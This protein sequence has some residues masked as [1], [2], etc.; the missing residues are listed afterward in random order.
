MNLS[1]HPDLVERLAA[2]YALG[3]LRAGARRRFET[4]AREQ[5]SLR[6]AALVWQARL[7]AVAELQQ[8]MA[9]DPVVWTR[10]ENVL[11][12]ERE[13]QAI[14][15]ARAAPAD[16]SSGA[17]GVSG[18][19]GVS[20]VAGASG[21]APGGW[22]RSVF[23]WRGVALA[24]AV[25]ATV[26]LLRTNGEHDRQLA[27]LSERHAGE[28]AALRAQVAASPQIRYVA[29][30]ADERAAASMLATYDAAARRLTLQRVG[31]YVEASDKSLQLWALPPGGG[32]PRSLGVLGAERVLR[33]SA[34]E[35]QVGPMPALAVSLEPR[36]GVPEATGPTGPVLFKGAVLRT[37]L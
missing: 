33:L 37:P 4:L 34:A 17:P 11:R 24:C 7:S 6:A 19:S 1:R 29:V 23:L 15:A 12:V 36:G 32:A 22:W 25:F 3:T 14:L 27:R 8:P 18:V 21:A 13:T 16:A 35:D 2:A 28:V 20:G 30:L 31:D 26:L 9:P 10:I 5:P